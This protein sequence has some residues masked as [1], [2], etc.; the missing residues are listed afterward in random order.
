MV[1]DSLKYLMSDSHTCHSSFLICGKMR[2][3]QGEAVDVENP[4]IALVV[5]SRPP[6]VFELSQVHSGPEKMLKFG[7][8]LQ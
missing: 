6:T 3:Y 1:S 7:A 4:I 5:P 2:F 8:V